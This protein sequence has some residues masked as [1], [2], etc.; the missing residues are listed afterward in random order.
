[1]LYGQ[2][3]RFK[4]CVASTVVLSAYSVSKR[5][6]EEALPGMADVTAGD[7]EGASQG[8]DIGW[9]ERNIRSPDL[10]TRVSETG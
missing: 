5:A 9:S 4:A 8:R 6:A 2:V 7:V 3:P 1:L 10:V